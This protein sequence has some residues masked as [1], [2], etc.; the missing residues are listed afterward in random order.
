MFASFGICFA[1]ATPAIGALQSEA[2]NPGNRATGLGIYYLWYYGGLA[3]TPALA[4]MLTDMTQ[5]A[6]TSIA[7]ASAMMVSCLFLLGLFRLEQSRRAPL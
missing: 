2:V 3:A 5:T 4:G 1:L 7:L 6:A